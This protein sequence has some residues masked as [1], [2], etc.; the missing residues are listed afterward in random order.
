MFQSS[1]KYE[2]EHRNYIE[3]GEVVKML[4]ELLMHFQKDSI[5]DWIPSALY[6]IQNLI[7]LCQECELN[8][9]VLCRQV[10]NIVSLSFLKKLLFIFRNN[11]V[12]SKKII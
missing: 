7:K 10:T 9:M 5:C 8:K 4:F 6:I 3:Y 2:V 1:T 11:L 12:S